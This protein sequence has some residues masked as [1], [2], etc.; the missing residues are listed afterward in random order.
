MADNKGKGCSF[1]QISKYVLKREN[2]D[3]FEALLPKDELIAKMNEVLTPFIDQSG[4]KTY[5]DAGIIYAM[6]KKVAKN[7]EL[8]A[9][10]ILKRVAGEPEEKKGLE[11]IFEN[12]VDIYELTDK[13]VLPEY[14]EDEEFFD[15]TVLSH[16]EDIVGCGQAKEA[17][18][19]DTRIYVKER[20]KGISQA[21]YSLLIFAGFACLWGTIMHSVALGLC[22]GACFSTCFGLT[23]ARS[24]TGKEQVTAEETTDSQTGEES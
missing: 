15:E 13:F 12:S 19:E 10:A 2:F 4:K 11:K 1:T 5:H 16:L 23:T 21:L 22:F 20:V 7:K 8:I 24:K 6:Y 17:Y 9:I 14:K 18:F 3:S